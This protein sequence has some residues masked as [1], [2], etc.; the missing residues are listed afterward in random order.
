M[1]CFC[2]IQFCDEV[3]TLVIIPQGGLAT[4]GYKPGTKVEIISKYLFISWQFAWTNVYRNK[5][6]FQRFLKIFF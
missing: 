3:V 6:I 1:R 4:F 2:F 5:A